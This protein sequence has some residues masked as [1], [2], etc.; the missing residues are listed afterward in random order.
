MLVRFDHIARIIVNVNDG[1]LRADEKL[2]AF[3][4]PESAILA[5]CDW[6]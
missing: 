4:E 3:L 1:I 2:T 6:S 5:C